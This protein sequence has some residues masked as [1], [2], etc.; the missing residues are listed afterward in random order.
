MSLPISSDEDIQP[1]S[2]ASIPSE[3][4]R[5]MVRVTEKPLPGPTDPMWDVAVTYTP[6]ARPKPYPDKSPPDARTNSV[7]LFPSRLSRSM[8]AVVA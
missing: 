4:L 2:P 1:G 8:I 5:T 7:C 6:G 3:A